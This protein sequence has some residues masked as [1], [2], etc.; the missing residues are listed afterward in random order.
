MLKYN[1]L[2]LIDGKYYVQRSQLQKKIQLKNNLFNIS[3][4]TLI[5]KCDNLKHKN[6]FYILY[7]DILRFIWIETLKKEKIFLAFWDAYS[8]NIVLHGKN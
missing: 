1:D 5:S 6:K 8:V 3:L 2:V 7:N 4:L